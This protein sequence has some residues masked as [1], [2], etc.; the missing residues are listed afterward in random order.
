MVQNQAMMIAALTRRR[1]K[2]H[3][4]SFLVKCVSIL[5]VLS[6][7]F[8]IVPVQA[9]FQDPHNVFC[10][11]DE[12]Y[13]VLGLEIGASK[14]AIKKAYRTISLDVHPDKNPSEE[15]KEKFTVSQRMFQVL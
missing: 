11:Q 15:A 14:A 7:S 5:A 2:R 8:V 10:G 9:Y 1:S 12:C 4:S 6:I 13:S 3:P